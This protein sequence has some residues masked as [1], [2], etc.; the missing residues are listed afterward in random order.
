M[1]KLSDYE[2]DAAIELWGDLIEPIA[3]LLADKKVQKIYRSKQPKVYIAK[4]ILK[5]HPDEVAR[6]LQRIDP[7]P[8]NGLTVITRFVALIND[9]ST[10]PELKDFFGSAVQEN[11]TT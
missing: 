11:Q 4:E 10:L 3:K 2:G 5:E 6:I 7:E 9:I 8:I 1:K